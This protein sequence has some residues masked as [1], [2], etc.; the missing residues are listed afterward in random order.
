MNQDLNPLLSWYQSLSPA[1]LHQVAELYSPDARFKDPFNEVQGT[2]AIEAIFKHMFEATQSP[3]F[4][5]D[6]CTQQGR[7][8]F[9]RWNFYFTLRSRD[10]CIHGV[11]RLQLTED[12]R[13]QDHRDYWDTGEELFQKLPYVGGLFRLMG[14]RFGTPKL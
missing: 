6:E 1:S 13:V 4:V 11:S 8:A 7:V 9:A 14:R 12:G 5:I 2:E 3:R 10:F